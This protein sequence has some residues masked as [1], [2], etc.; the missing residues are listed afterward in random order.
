MNTATFLKKRRLSMAAALIIC[1]CAG[2]GYAWSVLQTP[3]IA[4]HHWPDKQVSLTYTITVLCSTMAPLFFGS[5]IRKLS[6]GT[7]VT[8]GAILFGGGLFLTGWM[9]SGVWQLYLFYGILSGLGTGFIYPTL[10]AYV[11]RL[12]PDRSGMASGLG[13]AAY[14]SGAIFWAPVAAALIEGSSLRIAF[15]VL[16]AGFFVVILACT[17]LLR[18]PPENLREELHI[19]TAA[20][21]VDDGAVNLRRGEM[22]KT[23]PFYIMVLIFTCGLVAGVIVISQASPILQS[24]YGFTPA[25]AA[26]F[27][28]VFAA[29]N[30]AGRFLW[31]SLSDKLGIRSVMIA[32]FA[33]CI[34]SMTVLAQ[35]KVTTI[36]ILAM[37][38]AASCY[39]GFASVLTPLTAKVFGTKYVT[40]NYGVMYIVFGLASLIG[41]VL[42]VQLKNEIT[43]SY[44]GAF[45]AAG[46]LALLGLVGTIA[47]KLQV[48]KEHRDA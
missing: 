11:V 7:A 39:G 17:F 16:G 33:L 28:S 4:A 43:G 41:P 47:I 32:V 36:A 27:V 1:I 48:R 35:A 23:L 42:A 3:I 13:T 12:F 2:V 18:E 46:V 24:G 45:I 37:A 29:C 15:S 20:R 25:R 26:V 19:A 34:C 40:E 30:M 6:T 21:A 31:G 38:V 22:V 8:L 5:I 9:G 44:T 14:G 10:M